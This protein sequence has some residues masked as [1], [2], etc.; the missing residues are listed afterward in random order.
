[1]VCAQGMEAD[2][3][4]FSEL[5]ASSQLVFASCVTRALRVGEKRR[6][7][8]RE[9]PREPERK[10]RRALYPVEEG[11]GWVLVWISKRKHQG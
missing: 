1:M 7:Q 6:G 2:L 3:A 9:D 11:S 5:V 8:R 10:F 4:D